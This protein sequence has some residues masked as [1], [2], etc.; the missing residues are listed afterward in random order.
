MMRL[1]PAAPH[2]FVIEPPE[3]EARWFPRGETL[4]FGLVLVG[5]ALDYLAYFTFAFLR[6]G[7][8]GLGGRRGKFVL[9][10]VLAAGANGS[11]SIYRHA[12]ETLHQPPPFPVA[13]IMESRCRELS[14]SD[15]LSFHFLTPSRVKF[16]G[17][18]VEKPE[19]HHLIRSL[20]RRLSSL[21]YFH[22][23]TKLELDFRGLIERARAV[24]CTASDLHWMDWDRYSSRQKQRM[25]LG[26]F[27]GQVTYRG[28]FTQFL[29]L[30]A[31]GE[32]VHLGKAASFGLGRIA[33]EPGVRS[34]VSS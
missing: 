14:R 6:L 4:E 2:P 27:T 18:L 34:G 17:H 19:F 20:L 33:V 21:S 26:G 22:C 15:E 7:E 8:R 25:T 10:E 12:E 5:K 31:L 29:P 16:D 23:G 24:T 30:L 3:S 28:D 13:E 11:I 1:Y 32:I 9:D